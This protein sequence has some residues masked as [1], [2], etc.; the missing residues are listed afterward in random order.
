M[1]RKKYT[2]NAKSLRRYK[3]KE[4]RNFIKEN[5]LPIK[6]T[7]KLNK[8]E[9]ISNLLRLQRNCGKTN[10]CMKTNLII[11]DKKK[12]SP[13]QEQ[14]LLKGQNAMRE[15]R[16]KMKS[17]VKVS[18]KLDK[19]KP[20]KIPSKKPE[21]APSVKDKPTQ[22][23]LI[24]NAEGEMPEPSKDFDLDDL[25][26]KADVD[27]NKNEIFFEDLLGI[28]SEKPI[29][30]KVKDA[31]G[32]KEL[33]LDKW[34]KEDEEEEKEDGIEIRELTEKDKETKFKKHFM[35][36]KNI[37]KEGIIEMLRRNKIKGYSNKSKEELVDM[38]WENREKIDA[39]LD[40][41]DEDF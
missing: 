37:T 24:R 11:K 35:D 10:N 9:I 25:F 31:I 36:R 13:K 38:M 18:Q 21:P 20:I 4:L 26:K 16:A 32:D 39:L 6:R 8:T 40:W 28:S 2:H 34:V 17:V 41:S 19:K 30:D 3:V 7:S 1:P 15:R 23:E 29:G 12:L 27:I 22:L 33:D 14:A 5:K